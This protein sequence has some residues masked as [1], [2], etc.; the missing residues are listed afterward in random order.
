[1]P[2]K[3]HKSAFKRIRQNIKRRERNR[4]I[5]GS[6]RMILRSIR[7]HKKLDD[8]LERLT[9][10]VPADKADESLK[11]TGSKMY[12]AV[13]KALKKGVIHRRK[14]ARHK[15]QIAR[16]LNRITA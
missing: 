15:A 14:A 4:I 16:W 5:R 6:L 10:K 8:V 3:T 12:S 9:W 13:D 2:Y 11:L 7:T 1:M